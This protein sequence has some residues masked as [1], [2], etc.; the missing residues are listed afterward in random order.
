[1]VGCNNMLMLKV[2]Q[3][4]QKRFQTYPGFCSIL[5]ILF[6]FV[7]SVKMALSSVEMEEISYTAFMSVIFCHQTRW[8]IPTLFWLVAAMA[9]WVISQCSDGHL[10]CHRW[11]KVVYQDEHKWNQMSHIWM[12]SKWL[13][14][15]TGACL[16]AVVHT[17]THVCVTLIAAGI[18]WTLTDCMTRLLSCLLTDNSQPML[19]ACRCAR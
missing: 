10:L 7:L 9:N 5:F 2:C 4:L 16:L 6:S 19:P 14:S 3:S 17:H 18:N 15:A 11:Q 12:L 8:H 1:M 13:M